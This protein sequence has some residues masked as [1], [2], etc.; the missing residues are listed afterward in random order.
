[1]AIS[2]R[3]IEVAL[4]LW[5]VRLQTY[6]TGKRHPVPAPPPL[7]Q[8]AAVAEIYAWCVLFSLD[9]LSSCAISFLSC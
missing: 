5:T 1:M 4:L 7:G 6:A 2:K 8:A 9:L 3:W